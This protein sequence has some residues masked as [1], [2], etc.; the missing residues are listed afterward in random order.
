MILQ[1]IKPLR[2]GFVF[3]TFLLFVSHFSTTAQSTLAYTADDLAYRTGLELMDREKYGAAQKAF[4][5]YI[6]LGK[7]DL[8]SVDAKYYIAISALNLSNADAEP[9]IERFI[10]DYPNHPKAVM[11]Y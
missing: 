11:A 1:T 6:N 3:F 10:A 9:M 8:K 7:N 5:E 2:L 4:Q